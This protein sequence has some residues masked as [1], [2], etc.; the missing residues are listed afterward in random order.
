M[1]DK[2]TINDFEP[3]VALLEDALKLLRDRI[4]PLLDKGDTETVR[5]IMKAEA[6]ATRALVALQGGSD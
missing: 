5:R 3:E 6:D 2:Q 1:E 4:Q